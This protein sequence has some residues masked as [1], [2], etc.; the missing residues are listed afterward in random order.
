MVNASNFLDQTE[1]GR[2]AAT[3]CSTLV[4]A[5]GQVLRTRNPVRSEIHLTTS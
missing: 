4:R 1:P 2:D 5:C 3:F